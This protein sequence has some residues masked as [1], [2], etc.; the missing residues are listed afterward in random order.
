MRFSRSAR[1][2]L[3]VAMFFV[4]SQLSA[5]YPAQKTPVSD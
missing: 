2:G 1:I 5:Q 3:L 4:P